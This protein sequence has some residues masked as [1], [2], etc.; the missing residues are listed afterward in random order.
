MSFRRFFSPFF[1]S[2]FGKKREEQ[3]DSNFQFKEYKNYV[4]SLSASR[5]RFLRNFRIDSWFPF[6]FLDTS[7]LQI[8]GE[9]NKNIFVFAQ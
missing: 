6:I 8:L 2:A 5:P 3:S 1:F 7:F 9:G 4:R